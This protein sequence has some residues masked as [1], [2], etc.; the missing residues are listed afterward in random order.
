LTSSPIGYA[1]SSLIFDANCHHSIKRGDLKMKTMTVTTTK[2]MQKYQKQVWCLLV[3]SYQKVTGG[4]HFDSASDLIQK[5][6]RW[7]LVMRHK[8]VIAVTIFKAKRGWKLVAMAIA[9]SAGDRAKNA[10]KRL[11]RSDLIKSWMELSERA[12]IFVLKYCGGHQYLI[13]S[14]LV[15]SLLGKPIV[16]NNPDGFHY[17]RLVAGQVKAKVVVGTPHW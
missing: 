6:Q 3:E 2:E 16:V 5:T 15:A 12:E 10:L 4:L 11:I 17:H 14:S 13:H 7:R 8:K 1:T 9:R